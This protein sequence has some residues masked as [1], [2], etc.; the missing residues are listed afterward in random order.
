MNPPLPPDPKAVDVTMSNPGD[1]H[2]T[3]AP[4]AMISSP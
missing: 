3:S 2:E 1:S 4:S